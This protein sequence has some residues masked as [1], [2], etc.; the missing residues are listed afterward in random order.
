MN[1]LQLCQRL[2]EKSDISG[3]IASVALQRGEMLKVVNW[4]N[5]AWRDI[6]I[7]NTNWDWMRDDFS[8]ATTASVGEYAVAATGVVDFS[9]WHCDTFRIYRTATGVVDEN[10]MPEWDYRDFRDTYLY[11]L[12]VPGRPIVFAVK[13]KG[14]ALLLGALPDGIYTVRGEFQRKATLM[15]ANTDE[16]AMPEEYHMVIVHA[17]RMKYAASEN[18]PEVMAE[19][20]YDYRRMMSQL[21]EL[22]TEA[23]CTGAPLA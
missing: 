23:L 17:A 6:Q 16:P 12:Q 10:F 5:E 1:F 3:A 22:Q 9:K 21:A 19:A 7:S 13:P 14:S 18:A 2:I 4:V 15:V 8:F 11:G 20:Q